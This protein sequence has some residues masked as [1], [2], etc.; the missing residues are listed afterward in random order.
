[1]HSRVTLLNSKPS[2]C[3][4]PAAC[5]A[6]CAAA[7][8]PPAAAPAA[9]AAMAGSTRWSMNRRMCELTWSGTSSW[10]LHIRVGGGTDRMGA[11]EQSA[12]MPCNRH[13]HEVGQAAAL[14]SAAAA[15]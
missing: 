1:M 5:A 14:A 11:N 12:A 15:V 9:R 13:V 4:L 7:A 10:G 6:V 3:C 2:H 8:A